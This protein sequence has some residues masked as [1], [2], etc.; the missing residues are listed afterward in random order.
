MSDMSDGCKVLIG[1]AEYAAG[2]FI[3]LSR[4]HN[5]RPSA[6]TSFSRLGEYLWADHRAT[7]KSFVVEK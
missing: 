2:I 7:H 5:I 4:E 3:A 6:C 1:D